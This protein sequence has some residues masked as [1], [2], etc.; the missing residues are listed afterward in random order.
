MQAYSHVDRVRY[1]SLLDP[2]WIQDVICNGKDLFGMFPEA[3]SFGD[4]FTRLNAVPKTH[5]AVGLPKAVLE[6]RVRFKYLLPG[7]CIREA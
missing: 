6:N 4:L 2:A 1:A 5:S 7:G 3:F